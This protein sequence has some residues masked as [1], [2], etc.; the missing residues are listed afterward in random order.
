MRQPLEK[1]SKHYDDVDIGIV[2]QKTPTKA[3]QLALMETDILVIRPTMEGFVKVVYK[4]RDAMQ[5]AGGIMP[6]KIVFDHDDNTDL[7]SPFSNHYEE[8]GTEEYKY[9]DMFTEQWLE[10]NPD[11]RGKYFWQDGEKGLNI[12]AN[13]KKHERLYIAMATCDL[14]TATT[15]KL[16][17]Y[18][19]EQSGNDSYAVLPN[20]IDFKHYWPDVEFAKKEVRVGWAGG[21][22]HWEDLVSITEPLIGV[23]NKTGAKYVHCGQ[24][25]PFVEK[26]DSTEFHGW[27]QMPGHPYR[28]AMLNL[29]IGLI[30]LQP[31]LFNSYKS[32]IKWY[33]YSALRIP[34]LVANVEPYNKEIVHGETGYL[35]SSTEEFV[36]YLE[37]LIKDEAE[38]KRV[39]DNAYQWVKENRDADQQVGLWYDAYKSIPSKIIEVA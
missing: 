27:V 12:E 23:M 2:E 22:S 33:E 24:L 20:C 31:T 21:S 3:I 18:W 11:K 26:L 30:P 5:Q 16:A 17:K 34:S 6:T 25:F 36:E 19:S 7:V 13:K 32:N 4:M 9:D 1:L 39:G 37:M 38:R 14:I 10:E 15:E 29:D 8:W 35:Y 28:L